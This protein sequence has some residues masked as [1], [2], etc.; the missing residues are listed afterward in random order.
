MSISVAVSMTVAMSVVMRVSM[1]VMMV[2]M[3]VV[4][5][6]LT[7]QVIMSVT[8]VQNLH[9]NQVEDEAHDRDN[10]HDIALHLRRLPEA[11]GGLPEEPA[12]HDPN[13]RHRNKRTDD[14]CPM[15][16]VSQVLVRRV[17][18]H[19]QRK[20]RDAETNQVTRQV[21]RVSEN[22]NGTG[23]ISTYELGCNKHCGNEGDCDQLLLRR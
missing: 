20:N 4:V 18:R 3:V 15:P 5:L 23:H 12:S 6:M 11:Q 1:I 13:C 21:R 19:R 8:R 16:P 9:L 22:C 2:S 10:Q 17:L 14:F 7:A